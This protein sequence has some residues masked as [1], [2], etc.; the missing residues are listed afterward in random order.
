MG[1]ET[2]AVFFPPLGGPSDADVAQ[3]EA[4][5]NARET[6]VAEQRSAALVRCTSQTATGKGCGTMHPVGQLDY[7]Q[8]HSYVEPHG[9][10]GG[11]YWR[12]G[13]GNWICP[14]CGHRNRLYD[15]PEVE[16]LKRSFKSIT[17]THDRR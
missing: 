10:T 13:E 8:T 17:K 12:E 2:I 15:S 4:V 9:C 11:D 6:A 7:I 14:T 16:K 1:R 3:A 5:L